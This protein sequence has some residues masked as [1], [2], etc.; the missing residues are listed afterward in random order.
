M[1]E[2]PN[3]PKVQKLYMDIAEKLLKKLP[4]DLEHAVKCRFSKESNLDEISTTLQG[5]SIRTSI[6]RYNNHITGSK[7]DDQT[8]EAKETHDSESQQEFTTV[9][10]PITLHKISPKTGK[11]YLKERKEQE[12]TNNVINLTL[13]VWGMS[14]E[15]I[16]TVNLAPMSNILWNLRAM[17]QS[18]LVQST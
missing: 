14:V 18:K 1:V 11:R 3:N 5:V 15:R 12:K 16:N 8:L 13:I 6:V 4:G 17:E 7:R 9:N 2:Q 10:H